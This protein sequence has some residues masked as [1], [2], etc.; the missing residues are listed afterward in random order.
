MKTIPL[1]TEKDILGFDEIFRDDSI[2][3][4]FMTRLFIKNND[5][6]YA[7]VQSKYEPH[8]FDI[9]GGGFE[10]NEDF[11]TCATREALEEVG[12]LIENVMAVCEYDRWNEQDPRLH[13]HIFF[14]SCDLIS[15]D[16]PTSLD[17][18]EI[19]KETIWKTKD[20]VINLMNSYLEND[21]DIGWRRNHTSIKYMFENFV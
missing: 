7:L 5:G 9:P 4:R 2:P 18:R 10:A 14:C 12:A 13:F 3:T 1:L 20:E 21:N 15:L 17:P 6:R 19:G 11:E 16:L 8:Y